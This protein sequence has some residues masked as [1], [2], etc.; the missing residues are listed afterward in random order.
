MRKNAEPN[1]QQL[2]TEQINPAWADL[3]LRS[4]L[5]LA[6]II[7]QEDRKV[8]AAVERSLPQIARGRQELRDDRNVYR[9]TVLH[10]ADRDADDQR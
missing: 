4:S 2:G 10:A 5:D 9:R 3:D 6:Q 1:L 8:A 7:N